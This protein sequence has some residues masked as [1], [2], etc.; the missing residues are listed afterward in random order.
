MNAARKESRA[1]VSTEKRA[2]VAQMQFEINEGMN[3]CEY[4]LVLLLPPSDRKRLKKTACRE[5]I[6]ET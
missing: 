6:N 5:D 3:R 4:Q 2:A 1:G